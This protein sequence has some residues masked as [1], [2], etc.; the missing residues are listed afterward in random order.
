M[1]NAPIK[2][3]NGTAQPIGV[4]VDNTGRGLPPKD[5][6]T[7]DGRG[8]TLVAPE[9]QVVAQET[10]E[11]DKPTI[12]IYDTAGDLVKTQSFV[13]VPIGGTKWERRWNGADL[14]DD[15]NG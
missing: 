5:L 14:V 6:Q 12:Y 7:K 2:I 10:N 9:T 3:R 8:A 4:T 11:L 1:G 15:D 13:I